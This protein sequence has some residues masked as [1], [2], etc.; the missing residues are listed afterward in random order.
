MRNESQDW[1][2]PKSFAEVLHEVFYGES[3]D[4]IEPYAARAW[5]K[6]S[7]STIED[8]DG[9]KLA[10]KQAWASHPSP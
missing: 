6:L 8:W 1:I 9:I 3:W 2:D 7:S 10:I 4:D 5:M